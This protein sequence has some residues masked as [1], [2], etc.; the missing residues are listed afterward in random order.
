MNSTPV[1]RRQALGGIAALGAAAIAKP[2]LADHHA[3]IDMSNPA[4]ALKTRVKVMGSVGEQKIQSFLRF[5]IYGQMPDEPARPLFSMN[6]MIVA[7]WKPGEDDSYYLKHYETAYYTKFDTDE[8][9]ESFVN[10]Y[11]GEENEIFQFILGPINRQY[12]TN[13]VVAP[14]LAPLPLES[15]V[16]GDRIFV[17]TQSITQFPNI[18][19]PEDWPRRSTGPLVSWSSFMTYSAAVADVANPDKMSAPAHIQLQ[20]FVSWPAWML[21]GNK[22]GGTMARAYGTDIESTDAL[23][24]SI[25]ANFEKYTPEILE[26]EKWQT[27]R[28]DAVD[29]FNEMTKRKQAES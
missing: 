25:I 28:M 9:I 3:K 17:A 11:T 4:A 29:Y 2:S 21:M 7:Y 8:P 5:H 16:I 20:N 14:G 19:T 10:P 23:P 1:S 13:T 22:P 12:K 26:T 18:L 15:H 24:K 6:N 27:P